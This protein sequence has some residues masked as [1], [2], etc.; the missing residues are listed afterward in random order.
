MTL[1]IDQKTKLGGSLDEL[2]NTTPNQF[3]ETP[4]NIM[5]EDFNEE[6][7]EVEDLL[8][9]DLICKYYQNPL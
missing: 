9:A 6:E 4:H 3:I 8:E 2:I 7:K 1:S 5:N